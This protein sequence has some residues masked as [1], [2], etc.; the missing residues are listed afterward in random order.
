MSWIWSPIRAFH[1]EQLAKVA[2]A[3]A[4]IQGLEDEPDFEY[5]AWFIERFGDDEDFARIE[6]HIEEEE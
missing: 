3:I 2:G 4:H 1:I 6:E 5:F